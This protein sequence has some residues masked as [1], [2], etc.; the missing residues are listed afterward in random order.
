MTAESDSEEV[1]RAENTQ[2]VAD[3]KDQLQKAENA[4]DQYKKQ[5]EILQLRLDDAL[6]DQNSMEEDKYSQIQ[7]VETL[8]AQIKEHT[9]ERHEIEQ[10][11]EADQAALLKERAQQANKE[12][13]LQVVIRR[14]NETIKERETRFGRLSRRQ[15]DMDSVP[16]SPQSSTNAALRDDSQQVLQRDKIIESLQF[17]LAGAQIKI[18]ELEHTGDGRLQDLEKT[19]METRMNNAR[20]QDENESYQVL[21]SEKTLKGD[22]MTDSAGPADGGLG[23]LADELESAHEV[24]EG[25]SEAY[26]KLESEVKSLR[27]SNKALTL[28]IDTIIGRLLQHE[29]FEHIIHDKGAPPDV[30]QKPRYAE[31]ELPP[32]PTPTATPTPIVTSFLQ[33]A[34]SV[35]SRPAPPKSRPQ[36]MAQPPTQHENPNTAPSIP[37]NRGHR[38]V[39]SDQA[40]TMADVPETPASPTPAPAAAVVGQMY[41]GSPLRTISGGPTSQ[42]ISPAL[43]PSLGPQKSSYFPPNQSLS[44]RTPSGSGEPQYSSSNSIVSERSGDVHSYTDAS[45]A[46]HSRQAP[47]STS[48]E[49]QVTAGVMKQNQLRPLRL[50]REQAEVAQE[51]EAQRKKDNR[52]SWFGFFKGAAM[53][54]QGQMTGT[55][56]DRRGSVREG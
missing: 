56:P 5:V 4:S 35:V 3:L 22:F 36:S 25:E 47:V 30:P 17:D 29:G 6:K 55:T 15:S 20:L 12:E 23:S 44:A 33:R 2:L 41:R 45:S 43:S 14:L 49:S 39:R 53:E 13:E 24:S 18:A 50:V 8:Q 26:R 7:Q 11:H 48:K 38:R 37:L 51:E 10:V 54:S 46:E 28:Y 40:H 34:K 16:L 21:L 52:G 1:A 31:K 42:G 27:E 32:A 19:L 9:R